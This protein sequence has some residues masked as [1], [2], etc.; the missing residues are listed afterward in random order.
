VRR[1]VVLIVFA[2]ALPV[3]VAQAWTWPVNGPVLRPFS[4]DRAHPYAA[5]QHRGVD[6]GAAAG[7][8]VRAPVDGT[9]TFSGTVP[10][11]GKTVSIQTPSGYT[12]TLLHLG[13][14]GVTRGASV[15]EGSVVGT[16]GPSGTVDLAEPF[17]Y[18]G[19]RLTSDEQGYVDPLGLLPPR[20]VP[21]TP[22]EAPQVVGEAAPEIPVATVEPPAAPAV[23]QVEVPATAAATSSPVAS[24]EVATPAP[25]SAAAPSADAAVSGEDAGL[26]VSSADSARIHAGLPDTTRQAVV[27]E[28]PRLGVGGRPELSSASFDRGR[29]AESLESPARSSALGETPAGA[30]AAD[31]QATSQANGLHGRAA[32]TVASAAVSSLWGRLLLALAL[33]GLTV[34]AQR[35]FARRHR[36]RRGSA[37]IMSLPEPEHLVG[38]A[39]SEGEAEDPGRAGMAVRVGQATPRSRGGLRSPG[40]HL[41]ALPPLEGERRAHG[42]R[43]GRARHAGHGDRRSRRRLAA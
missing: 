41:R 11:G 22:L 9:V 37:R 35:L 12:A 23:P 2:L 14:I 6:L 27:R 3:S 15:E 34:A 18:F 39:E 36:E 16:V 21:A 7:A 28:S 20:A 31:R 30:R 25:V 10:S 19:V 1:V 8:P 32:S 24:G 4:F 38:E 43:D 13:S 29:F 17:V 33:A 40:G 42:E 26:S 5:G